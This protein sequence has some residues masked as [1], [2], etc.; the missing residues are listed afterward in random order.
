MRGT[1]HSSHEIT[2]TASL[3][4]PHFLCVIGIPPGFRGL[5]H[6]PLNIL[7]IH[8]NPSNFTRRERA[9]FLP[10]LYFTLDISRST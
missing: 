2:L 9:R 6:F 3:T 5:H 8:S 10:S 1:K 7:D 4:L